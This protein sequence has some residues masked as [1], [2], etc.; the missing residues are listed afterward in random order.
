MNSLVTNMTEHES[1]EAVDRLIGG[2][3]RALADLFS[4]CRDRLWRMAHFRLDHRLSGRVDADDVLQESYLAATKRVGQYIE[5]P[6]AYPS[7]FLWLR[8]VV[9]QTLVDIHR[10]HLNAQMRDAGREVSIQARHYP[11]ATSMSLAIHLLGHLTS[12]SNAAVRAEMSDKLQAS[13]DQ[14]DDVDREVLALRHFEEL[15]NR[16]VAEVLKIQQ[17]AAS[18]RY[19]RAIKRLKDILE[20]VPDNPDD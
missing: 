13:L 7:F 6:D 17:N 15:T 10:K 1:Q 2:D 16:E 12:P 5:Q 9:G 18:M 14:M 3:E 11:Q 20:P 8:L 19:V 4:A